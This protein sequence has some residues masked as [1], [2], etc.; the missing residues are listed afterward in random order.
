MCDVVVWGVVG[1]PSVEWAFS[2]AFRVYR[3]VSRRLEKVGLWSWSWTE[4]NLKVACAP[5]LST[6]TPGF[7]QIVIPAEP[8]PNPMAVTLL[9]D[10][11]TATGA[12]IEYPVLKHYQLLE[13]C[14]LAYLDSQGSCN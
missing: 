4:E 3:F 2:I 9:L 8:D 7:H 12:K 11:N 13:E 6:R 5:G 1:Y 14:S 10:H